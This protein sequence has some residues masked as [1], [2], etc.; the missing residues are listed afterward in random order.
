[1]VFID[2]ILVCFKS[3]GDHAGNL[4]IVLQVLK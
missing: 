1:M 3:D 4:R 2:D